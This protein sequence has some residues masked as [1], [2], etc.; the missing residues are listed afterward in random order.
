MAVCGL[1]SPLDVANACVQLQSELRQL[2]V[3]PRVHLDMPQMHVVKRSV[4][5]DPIA[6]M[7]DPDVCDLT[8]NRAYWMSLEGDGGKTVGLQAF[9]MDVIGTSLADWCAAYMIGVYMLRNELMVPSHSKPP[10]NS[11]SERLRG[12]LVYHGEI[13]VDK[14]I[15]NRRVFEA[16]TRLGIIIA[17]IKW[18]P[19]AIWG[20]ASAQMAGHGHVG[21]IGYTTIE[22]G[23]LRWEWASEGIDPVEYL[24]V[25]E[26]PALEAM[27]EEMV[28]TKA[29][30]QPVTRDQLHSL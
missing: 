5:G 17:M 28:T 10:K 2:G 20:L 15:R 7:H 21:R 30:S 1:R 13:W 3:E 29:V 16:F 23:F 18:N 12:K 25:I 11:I 6:P 19:D 14:Q 27:I 9:R 26:R 24:C 8:G 22:R 4:R